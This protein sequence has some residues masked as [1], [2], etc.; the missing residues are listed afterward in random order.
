MLS[1]RGA[2]NW[3]VSNLIGNLYPIRQLAKLKTL[4]KFPAVWY[5]YVTVV[6][7]CLQGL[8][9]PQGEQ[10]EEGA[11]GPPVSHPNSMT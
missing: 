1:G 10:G 5:N 3:Q 11:K 9:G 2:H 7:P 6:N 8:R 4:P